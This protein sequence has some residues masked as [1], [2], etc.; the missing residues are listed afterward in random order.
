MILRRLATGIAVLLCLN[1]SAMAEMYKIDNPASNIDN[2]ATRMN[3][4]NPLSPPT[5][6]APQPIVKKETTTTKPVEPKPSKQIKEQP[7]SK[8]TIHKIKYYSKRARIYIVAAKIA[9]DKDDYKKVVAITEDAL[10]RISAGKLKASKKEKQML[11][12][13]KNV[14][15]AMLGKK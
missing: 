3:N 7:Q 14:G 15:Y 4:P 1:A 10:R 13:Y 11:V 12:K 6:P 9:F 5:Q 8:P 2:P